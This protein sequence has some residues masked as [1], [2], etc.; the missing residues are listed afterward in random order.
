MNPSDEPPSAEAM[1]ANEL[2]SDL[3]WESQQAAI[4]ADAITAIRIKILALVDPFAALQFE[5]HV[6]SYKELT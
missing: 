6:K 5:E 4:D 1:I 3:I 2:I